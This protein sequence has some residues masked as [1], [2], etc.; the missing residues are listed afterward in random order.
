MTAAAARAAGSM[1]AMALADQIQSDLTAAMKARDQTTTAALRSAVA[2]IRNARVAAGQSGDLTDE[3]TTDLLGREAKKRTEAAD[4]FEQA[5]RSEQAEKER[6]ELAV[7]RRYLPERLDEV[8]LRA[9]VDEAVSATGASGPGDLGR[10]MGAVMPRV[11]GRADGNR[12]RAL[13]QERLGGLT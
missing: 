9:V 11:K 6:A 7:L 1:A 5:G 3:Q 13:V 12:V 2:A 10:V 4:A 8:E